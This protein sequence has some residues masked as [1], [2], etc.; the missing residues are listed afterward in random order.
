MFLHTKDLDLATGANVEHTVTVIYKASHVTRHFHMHTHANINPI[1]WAKLSELS[2]IKL[3]QG[4]WWGSN[5]G[6]PIEQNREK[7]AIACLQF[8][9]E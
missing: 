4:N 8:E 9:G 2:Q 7:S 1:V 3:R 5:G 6:P